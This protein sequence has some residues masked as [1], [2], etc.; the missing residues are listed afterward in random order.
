MSWLEE[1]IC[2]DHQQLAGGEVEKAPW[3]VWSIP[4]G[5]QSV[6]TRNQG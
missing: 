4:D 1:L 5:V 3:N 2:R 6:S